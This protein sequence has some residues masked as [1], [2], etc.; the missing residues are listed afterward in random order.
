MITIA[1]SFI[2]YETLPRDE[3]GALIEPN[4]DDVG[5]VF[6]GCVG[7]KDPLRP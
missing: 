1:F 5:A 2:D 6:I 7:I 4:D 3:D